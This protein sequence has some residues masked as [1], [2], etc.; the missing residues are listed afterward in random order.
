MKL[1]KFRPL[2]DERSSDHIIRILEDGKF[3]CSHFWELNDPMEGVYRRQSSTADVNEIFSDKSGRVICSFSGK[4]ALNKPLMWGYYANGFKGLVI[5]LDVDDAAVC[6]M[7]YTP[8][9]VC[10]DATQ[11]VDVQV[12][13][14]L[15]NKLMPWKHENEYRYIT[16]SA[17][18]KHRIGTIAA[19]ILGVPYPKTL[20]YDDAHGRMAT[21]NDYRVRLREINRVAIDRGMRIDLASMYDGKV[22]IETGGDLDAWGAP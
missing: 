6:E 15:T 16:R 18:N 8:D 13:K 3:W 12:R 10:P 21:L 7:T 1:Y 5:E 11:P 2:G 17:D 20:A 19:V 9:V 14:I 22:Q 4:R